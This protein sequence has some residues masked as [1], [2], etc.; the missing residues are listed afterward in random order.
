MA[1]LSVS[2]E[3]QRTAFNNVATYAGDSPVGLNLA[4]EGRE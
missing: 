4:Q 2:I 3:T 1:W